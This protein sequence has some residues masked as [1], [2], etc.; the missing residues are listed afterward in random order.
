MFFREERCLFSL[1]MTEKSKQLCKK[2]FKLDF[3]IKFDMTLY[4]NNRLLQD[5]VTHCVMHSILMFNVYLL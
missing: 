5:T 2:T 4:T 1:M 3:F